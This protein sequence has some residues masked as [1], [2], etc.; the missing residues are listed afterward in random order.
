M[1]TAA[2]TII[3]LVHNIIK[4]TVGSYNIGTS[5]NYNIHFAGHTTPIIA[6]L[7]PPKAAKG[8]RKACRIPGVQRPIKGGGIMGEWYST[9]M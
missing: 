9:A 1:T 3:F 8:K 4:C 5:E 6:P 7:R 2:A